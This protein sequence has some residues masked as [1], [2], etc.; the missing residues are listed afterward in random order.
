MQGKIQST[1]ASLKNKSD[2]KEILKNPVKRLKIV[3]LQ[4]SQGILSLQL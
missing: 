3:Y 1:Y 2:V 4:R